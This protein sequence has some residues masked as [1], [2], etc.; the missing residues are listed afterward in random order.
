ML[1][2]YL[3]LVL[4]FQTA[5]EKQFWPDEEGKQGISNHLWPRDPDGRKWTSARMR[6]AIKQETAEGLGQQLTIQSYREIAIGISR[7]FMR[8]P[9]SFE[10]DEDD[11]DGDLNEDNIGRKLGAI[12]DKQAGHTSHVAGMIYARLLSEMSGSVAEQRKQFRQSSGMWH[13]F[14]GFAS[15]EE[16]EGA[17]QY[18]VNADRKRM[19]SG[20][21]TAWEE[22]AEQTRVA[23]WKWLKKVDLDDELKRMIGPD[24]EFR[25]T[26]KPAIEAIV[27]GE[28]RVV[29]VMATG[30][31]KS[32]LFMLP[33]ICAPDGLTVVV[34]PLIALRQNMIKRCKELGIA[35]GEWVA[36]KQFD[37]A[38][39]VFVTPESAVS[40][41][42]MSFLNR[43]KRR[44]DRIVID[45]C[46]VILNEDSGFRK[47]MSQM[48]RLVAA[49]SQMV[50]L[51]ATL[52]PSKEQELWKRMFW[53]EEEV[54]M[55][56]ARTTR[57]NIRYRVI[58]AVG[59]GR[60]RLTR[61]E[62]DRFVVELIEKK[63]KQY[64]PGKM[65]VYC[66]TKPKVRQLA[67]ELGVDAYYSDA[68]TKSE[69]LD[70]FITG[71]QQL[72]VATSAL[73][74]GIDIPDIRAVIHVDIPRDFDEYVQESG[75]AG[76][77]RLRSEAIIIIQ[78]EEEGVEQGIG[79][80]ESKDR[81]EREKIGLVESFI[82]ASR[83]SQVGR[84]CRRVVLDGYIDRGPTRTRCK[85]GEEACDVCA[86]DIERDSTQIDEDETVVMQDQDQVHVHDGEEIGRARTGGRD[87][88]GSIAVRSSQGVV[89]VQISRSEVEL[90]QRQ[91]QR[92]RQAQ[93]RPR[94]RLIEGVQE[95]AEVWRGLGRHLRFWKT[96]CSWCTVQGKRGQGH[97]LPECSEAGS[98]QA[99]ED[100]V[101]MRKSMVYERYT[102]CYDCGA[103]QGMCSKFR[104]RSKGGY[105]RIG[106]QGECSYPDT[107]AA[108]WIGITRGFGIQGERNWGDKMVS[109]GL[110][111]GA[112]MDFQ[113]GSEV[114]KI[115][116]SRVD[117]NGES[118]SR[119]AFEFQKAASRAERG[120][121]IRER[122]EG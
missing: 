96:R 37:N 88:I 40:P 25:G 75:R 85:E 77:D 10:P 60:R 90:W 24:A 47:R 106:G 32:V 11:E 89:D 50:L 22:Q 2:K 103:P 16:E 121:R 18:K 56:R 9:V 6:N 48:G 15:A 53:E 33:A 17:E 72:I 97:I 3:W 122:G 114:V 49:E 100:L 73:G 28:P 115:L 29:A 52:P 76:R 63:F 19:K 59:E 30:E 42:F 58:E 69:K 66:N 101:G 57:K 117:L 21:V 98:K 109:E 83:S 13:A 12:A 108:G 84:I 38:S 78:G 43:I 31:G 46:H 102:A 99:R 65:I 110:H 79:G 41:G 51:T 34:V 93:S 36:G 113:R 68:D 62:H 45:E 35:C 74:L 87:E 14:L 39:M 67:D 1:I 70:D 120:F 112:E 91:R 105:S 82:Q 26:Q 5:L 4:P 95:A 94:Q 23:R 86:P 7:R 55:F 8:G 27:R 81:K 44:L 111:R 107:V 71:R 54:C 64:Q 119:L 80:E 92:Q 20:P 116:G 118:V 61:R 104:A